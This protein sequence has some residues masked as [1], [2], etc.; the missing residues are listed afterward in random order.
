M[1]IMKGVVNYCQRNNYWQKE[2]ERRTEIKIK[3]IPTE[4]EIQQSK[5]NKRKADLERY[6]KKLNY[7]TKLYNTKI[8][9]ANRSL[10]MLERNLAK[11]SLPKPTNTPP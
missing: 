3:P 10:V 8:K 7:Y 9:K 2:L 6:K 1:R 11:Q 4:T 5:L